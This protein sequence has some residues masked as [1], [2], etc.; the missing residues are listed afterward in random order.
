MRW[1][2]VSISNLQRLHRWS[3]GMAK[4]FHPTL[5]DECDSL[6]MLGF[7]LIHVKGPTAS[8][9]LVRMVGFDKATVADFRFRCHF[10]VA[11]AQTP[12]IP[13]REL[14]GMYWNVNVILMKFSR[15]HWKLSFWK[16]S[17]QTATQIS[18]KW[19]HVLSSFQCTTYS[20]H[21]MYAHITI[22]TACRPALIFGLI[23]LVPR[24]IVKSL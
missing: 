1:S 18:S 13:H 5:Y 3:L 21:T 10:V 9:P 20:I 17:M 12:T 14:Y 19:R 7:K 2:Y 6:S 11:Y 15:V 4:W 8:Y 16:L 23:I 22:I 24:H